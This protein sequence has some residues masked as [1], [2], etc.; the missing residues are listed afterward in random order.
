MYVPA[1]Q[2]TLN[3]HHFSS[4]I[5][6]NK[7]P[8]CLLSF[9]IYKPSYINHPP[10]LLPYHKYIYTTSTTYHVY[11]LSS[12][13]ILSPSLPPC[14]PASLPPFLPSSLPP[15]LPLFLSSQ[16]LIPELLDIAIMSC[17]G[18]GNKEKKPIK[19]V[20]EKKRLEGTRGDEE[21]R[22]RGGGEAKRRGEKRVEETHF[23]M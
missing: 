2:I 8:S 17:F 10:L 22:R 4:Y 16:I 1:P 23:V 7:P 9:N 21:K 3:K 14:L 19:Y 15:S 20:K 6:Y 13:S 5:K 11:S 12:A 18:F